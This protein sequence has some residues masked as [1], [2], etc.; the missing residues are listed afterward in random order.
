[1]M[2]AETVHGRRRRRVAWIAGVGIAAVLACGGV[3]AGAAIGAAPHKAGRT[4]DIATASIEKGN[5]SGTVKAPGS[6]A[7]ASVRDVAS[8]VSGIL[9]SA[10]RPGS[11]VSAGQALFSVDNIA[12][13]LF[14]GDLPAW[15]SFTSGM[16]DGPDVKQLEQNLAALGH[17]SREPDEEFTWSTT[18]AIL[19]WQKGTGQEQTGSIDLGRIVFERG[20]IRVQS[21]KA[22]IGSPV[23]GGPVLSV[24][25]LE[26]QISAD[27]PL[28]NQQLANVGGK[29][30]ITLPDGKRTPG[31]IVSVGTP[32][33]KSDSGSV[34]IPVAIALDDPAAAGSLQQA[35]VT[36]DFPSETRENVLS[37]PAG[38]LMAFSESRFGVEVLGADHTVRRVP[39]TTGL[40]AGG[41]VE[42]S[43]D[44]LKAGQKVVVP[45]I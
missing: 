34:I 19:A 41:R 24:T 26:K 10:P 38:A 33:E 39:V 1:M 37:V 25:D 11:T 22:A 18:E 23:G 3:I 7:F 12:V 40:F 43:G 30:A 5:L 32:Q 15:R 20:D 17:F 9:T 2:T 45:K 28:A 6:L 4:V 21:L 8:G 13:H 36:V 44:G 29:V 14:H 27:L 31:T 35:T 16:D 42:I